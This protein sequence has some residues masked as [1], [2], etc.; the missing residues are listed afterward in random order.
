MSSTAER[1]KARAAKREK[2]EAKSAPPSDKPNVPFWHAI[3][4]SIRGWSDALVF[5]Y[6]LAMF[7]RIFVFELFMIPTGSMTPTLIGDADRRV[8]F[9]DYNADGIQDVFV[10]TESRERILVYVMGANGFPTESVFMKNVPGA[11]WDSLFQT[12]PGRTDMILVNKFAYWF[13]EPKRGDIIVFKVPDHPDR[14]NNPFDPYKP[15]FIKRCVG[16][17]NEE[18]VLRP[19]LLDNVPAGSPI[20][21]GTG[22]PKGL[23]TWEV[24]LKGRPVIVNGKE[25]PATDPVEQVIHFPFRWGEFSHAEQKLVTG[26]NEVLMIG[27]HQHSSSDSRDWGP[28]P[29]ENLRGRAIVRYWPFKAFKFLR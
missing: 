11:F 29:V 8:A 9:G 6:L 12:S 21:S 18:V 27:D 13:S 2:N 4:L 23:G 26:D 16:L 24:K 14:Q 15:I 19:P 22:L 3:L 10:K 17:P 7:I 28:V 20:F 1:I 5:A 25:L